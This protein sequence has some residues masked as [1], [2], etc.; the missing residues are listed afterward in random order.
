[1]SECKLNTAPKDGSCFS[2]ETIEKFANIL[3][4]EKNIT[5]IKN[6][7]KCEN[8]SCVLATIPK[9]NDDERH[10][11]DNK[12]LKP[13]TQSYDHNYW[14][15]NTELDSCMMQFRDSFSGF[16]YGFIHMVDKVMYSPVNNFI[17]D[18]K[19]FPV[20]EINFA[21]EFRPTFEGKPRNSNYKISTINNTPLT[22]Y[23]VIFNTDT[24]KGSGQHWYAIYISTDRKN[25]C[26]ERMINIELF[27]SSGQDIDNCEFNEFWTSV[28]CDIQDKLNI[29][30]KFSLVSKIQH[31]G[32]K[33]GNCGS[34]SM[35]Y[36]FS[37]LNGAIVED[38][39]KQGK[40]ISDHSMRLFREFVFRKDNQIL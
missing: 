11:L 21:E 22:S 32:D 27:N 39:D 4:T 20:T 12:F 7:L 38:F 14:L 33:T 15:N 24:S 5:T 31:Q 10:K 26:G 25:K 18:Y 8:D 17:L 40:V 35:F 13:Y 30:C 2:K 28:A 3:N 16:G 19:V 23:G 6:K 36:I 34:Y 1:M 29:D 9:L 37:R